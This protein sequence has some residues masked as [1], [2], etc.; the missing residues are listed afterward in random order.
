MAITKRKFHSS[1]FLPTFHHV[2]IGDLSVLICF[3]DR[4]PVTRL[5]VY[6]LNL[7]SLSTLARP[8]FD[9]DGKL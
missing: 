9:G 5:E 7:A 2:L 1:M 6:G 8:G 3:R 4:V